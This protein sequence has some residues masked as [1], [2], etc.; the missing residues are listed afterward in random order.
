M[1]TPIDVAENTENMYSK[2]EIVKMGANGSFS[3]IPFSQG[4]QCI[5]DWR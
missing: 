2:E 1:L 3:A 5:D 4:Q